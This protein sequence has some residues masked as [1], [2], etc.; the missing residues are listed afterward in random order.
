MYIVTLFFTAFSC[1]WRA[2]AVNRTADPKNFLIFY[3]VLFCFLVWFVCFFGVTPPSPTGWSLTSR[4]ASTV[5]AQRPQ[6]LD[7]VVTTSDVPH[8]RPV[9]PDCCLSEFCST[10]PGYWDKKSRR[11]CEKSVLAVALQDDIVLP[12]KR[13][14]RRHNNDK[15]SH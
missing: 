13:F 4:L 6:H 10:A 3:F 15:T 12:T 8:I 14:C 1:I 11:L 5:W 7:L 9:K 2:A